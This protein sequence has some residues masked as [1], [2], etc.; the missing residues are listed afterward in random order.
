M[1]TFQTATAAHKML[2]C[3]TKKRSQLAT[4]LNYGSNQQRVTAKTQK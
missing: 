1:H 4:D 3:L 2:S